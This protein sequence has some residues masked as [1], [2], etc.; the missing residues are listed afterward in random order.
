MGSGANWISSMLMFGKKRKSSN[1]TLKKLQAI[2]RKNRINVYKPRKGGGGYTKTPLTMKAL[3]TK[4]SRARVSYVKSPRKTRKTRKTARDRTYGNVPLS[5]QVDDS[6]LSVFGDMSEF[7]RRL[8]MTKKAVAAR[9]A[10]RLRSKRSRRRSPARGRAMSTRTARSNAK[11]AMNLHHKR[12]ISLKQAWKIVQK[13]RFGDEITSEFGMATV[14]GRG[15][16]PNT[17]WRKGAGR[18]QKRC[19]KGKIK[20]IT[21]NRLQAVALKNGVSIYKS[22]KSGGYTKTPLTAKSLKGRLSRAKVSYNYGRND[23]LVYV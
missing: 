6:D 5:R 9:R 11:K 4:L 18:G 7:G 1:L 19:L 23:S 20:K 22:S 10:Y 21:L 17:K 16:S 12:G 14:C 8:K 3:K 13:S 2:A 15:Y